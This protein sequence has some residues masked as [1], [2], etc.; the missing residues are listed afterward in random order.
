M[1]Q[2]ESDLNILIKN[3][4]LCLFTNYASTRIGPVNRTRE[5]DLKKRMPFKLTFSE[6]AS[7]LL[8]INV[9]ISMFS[10]TTQL[11]LFNCLSNC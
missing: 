8:I 3:Y 7:D 5:S 2:I 6:F 11:T 4:N 10:F 9:L 1:N